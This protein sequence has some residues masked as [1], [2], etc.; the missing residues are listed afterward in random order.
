MENFF[1]YITKPMKPDDVELWFKVND[2][3]YEKLELF[4][5]FSHTLYILMSETYFDDHETP[6]E[7][8]IQLSD[9]DNVNH[10]KWCWNKTIE[11]FKQENITFKSEGDHYVY[12]KSF[13]DDIFYNQKEMSVK[14]S[15]DV[16]FNDLFN[17]DKP[18]TKSDLDMVS[19]I[20]KL[21]DKNIEK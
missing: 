5:D 2:I 9:E 1:N 18:F 15:I 3:I 10:F 16:F 4:S 21:L 12:F 6:K 17:L 14:K 8:K 11:I 20:Y 13:F 7:T 19:N